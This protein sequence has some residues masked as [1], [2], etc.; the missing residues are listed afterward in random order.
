MPKILLVEDN[1]MNRDMLSCRLTRKGYDIVIAEDGRTRIPRFNAD[2]YEPAG[3]QWM[4]SDPANQ[5]LG[6]NLWDSDY[7]PNGTCDGKRP[8]KND[9]S[10]L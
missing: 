6:R 7:R 9:G 8:G 10:R 2:E 3:N 1:E 4:G 5:E